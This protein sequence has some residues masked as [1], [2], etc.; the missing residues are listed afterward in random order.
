MILRVYFRTFLNALFVNNYM[1]NS[2]L[3]FC[4][5]KECMTKPDLKKIS[6]LPI[7]NIERQR[8]FQCSTG[9]TIDYKS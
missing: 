1:V 6:V 8:F 2:F 3:K 9:E 7:E 5:K 4:N